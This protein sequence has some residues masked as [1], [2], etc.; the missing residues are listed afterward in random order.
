LLPLRPALAKAG[1]PRTPDIG[2]ETDAPGWHTSPMLL[3]PTLVLGACPGFGT[4]TVGSG[5]TGVP[6]NPTYVDHAAPILDSYCAPCHGETTSG[7]APSDFRLDQYESDADRDGAYDKR[8]RIAARAT[9][10]SPTMPPA[11]AA[12]PTDID[13]EILA[14]WVDDGAPFGGDSGSTP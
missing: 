4:G 8:D 9:G 2:L 5:A 13:R 7:G 11:Y 10:E 14:A 6:E 3:L 1:S 12:Q